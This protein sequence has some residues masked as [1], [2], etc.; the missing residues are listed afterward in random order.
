MGSTDDLRKIGHCDVAGLQKKMSYDV[1]SGRVK[2]H[3]NSHN[4]LVLCTICSPILLA[5]VTISLTPD[6]ASN[7]LG[8]Q[9]AVTSVTLSPGFPFQGCSPFLGKILRSSH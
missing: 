2:V 8:F 9:L 5:L 4:K 6:P 3:I 1:V 7:M